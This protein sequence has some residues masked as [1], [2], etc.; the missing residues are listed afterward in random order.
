M[1]SADCND[2]SDKTPV[3][4]P[5][6]LMSCSLEVLDSIYVTVWTIHPC[7]QESFFIQ[8]QVRKEEEA[9]VMQHYKELQC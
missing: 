1:N 7:T 3:M 9:A 5:I 8:Q 2:V 6:P 4:S